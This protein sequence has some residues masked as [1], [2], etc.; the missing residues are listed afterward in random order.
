MTQAPENVFNGL[1]FSRTLPETPGVYR[2]YDAK[3]DLL[4]VGK[5]R[6]LRRRVGSY[7][8]KTPED[9][10]IASMISKVARMEITVVGSDVEAL[11][12]ESEF[13]RNQRPRYNIR[14][15]EGSGYPYLHIDTQNPVP[16]LTI[17]RG[18]RSAKG[19]T[20]GP[21]PSGYAVRE[22]HD[23][24]LKHFK[25]RTCSDSFFAARNRPCL[26]YQIGRCS[27]PCVGLVSR[28]QYRQHVKE[29]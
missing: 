15:K 12:L 18:N 6:I 29:V 27:A 7:F 22:A 9:P 14:L 19:R 26:E 24:L 4:Y 8:Q 20:F 16:K 17:L 10:R 28:E 21:F 3:G 23:A 11:V 25:L 1:E 5:A 2:M 13:I